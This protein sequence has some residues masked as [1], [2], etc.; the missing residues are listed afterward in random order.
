MK[1]PYLLILATLLTALTA[2]AWQARPRVTPPTLAAMLPQG[3]LLTIESP[4]FAQL[5]ADWNTSPQAKAWLA[6]DDYK[7]F[8]NSRL[9]GRLSDAQDQF[10]ATAF[11]GPPKTRQA[12]E[13]SQF[14]KQVAGKQSI[15]A[16]YS[17]GNLEF[18]YITRMASA[19][20]LQSALL[21]QRSHFQQRQSAGIP[22]YVRVSKE[23][24]ARTVAFATV[25]DPGG[26]G[27]LLLLA[28]R[29]DLLANALA[30]IAGGPA[31]NAL[32]AEPWYAEASTALP[33]QNSILHM[34]LNL[35]R[36][37]P[38][39]YFRTYWIQQNLTDMAQYR[40]AVA[41]LYR[42]PDAF[43][44]ERILF[45]KDSPTSP[46]NPPDLAALA[47]LA[48]QEG[49]FRATAT[50]D[51]AQAI[52][53]LEEKLLGRP[54]H[55]QQTAEQAPE[56]DLTPTSAGTAT[57]LETRIDTPEPVSA[58]Y[59]NEALTAALKSAGFDA[60]LTYSSATQP[61]PD[62][63]LWVPIHNAIA[64]HA[65]GT[66]DATKL[67]A[68]VQ[69][70]LRGSLTTGTLGIE[71]HPAAN[72]TYALTGP[73]PL[74]LAIQGQTALLADDP[75]LLH[76]LQ[77]PATTVKSPA[78]TTLIAGFNHTAQRGPYTRLTTLIDGTNTPRTTPE[79]PRLL[80]PKPPQP[81]RHLCRPAIR[82]HHPIPPGPE[83][84]PNR[85]LPMALAMKVFAFTVALSVRLALFSGAFSV[86]SFS[87][88]QAQTL[89]Q[90]SLQTALSRTTPNLEI[91]VL[92]PQT[93]QIVANTFRSPNTPIP[94]GS[95][96]KPFLAQAYARTHRSFP[97][98]P[99][100][101][102]LGLA[103]ALAQ[104]CN[105]YFLALAA[106]IDPNQL[107]DLP[108]PPNFDPRNLIGLTPA[109][110]IAPAALA[111]AYAALLL[112][113]GTRP[114]ILEGMRLAAANGTASRIGPHP[115]GVLAKT[116]TAPCVVTAQ[117]QC[118]A[119]GDGL[120]LAAVPASRP[121]L[122]L[123]VRKRAT[124]GATAAFAAGPVLT[125]LK[126]LHAY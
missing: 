123:L 75:S 68:A 11:A 57:D 20:Q 116:G 15:F 99:C 100:P 18:L 14:L 38:M 17:V 12:P 63:P 90:Q 67:Q 103:Q 115:G 29:E 2:W 62:A 91:L 51:P 45:P 13:S 35:E 36:L 43:R 104:S 95:L 89:Y 87:P 78:A 41:D 6:G 119:N 37:V 71:F 44:E 25:P 124:N 46:A 122:L 49:V 85:P 22:F 64:L 65:T 28:T 86:L 4:D 81:L 10:F 47:A 31:T 110:P 96:L 56:A 93:N 125:Q 55:V 3:A 112:S 117:S 32:T 52:A 126:A 82:A 80:L 54:Q 33:Q 101:K 77:T 7:V 114:Q 76:A 108:A 74:Y 58:T 121:T 84:P 79:T 106:Q 69:Q 34:V 70:A 107:H 19:Q 9:F 92:N 94:T 21:Q 50:Q 98:H 30:L 39:P 73:R 27:D 66:W 59:S 42:A 120:V 5:L 61:T 113:P 102:P 48:P 40:A 88:V 83:P 26:Q 72:G 8:S 60:L 23:L 109:W 16:W 105:A 97:T 1:R 111:R 118:K 24:P 53:A